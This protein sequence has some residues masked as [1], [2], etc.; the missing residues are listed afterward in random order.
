MLIKKVGGREKSS[1]C[2]GKAHQR[3]SV[4][5]IITLP[6]KLIADFIH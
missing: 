5:C 4:S 1:W 2:I 3:G 6:K